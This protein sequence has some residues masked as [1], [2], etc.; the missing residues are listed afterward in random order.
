MRFECEPITVVG[1][2]T[3]RDR[4]LGV[5]IPLVAAFF[6]SSGRYADGMIDQNLSRAATLSADSRTLNPGRRRG[7]F[8]LGGGMNLVGRP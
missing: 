7:R 3:S 4:R 5:E 1:I 8:S 2:A 6:R